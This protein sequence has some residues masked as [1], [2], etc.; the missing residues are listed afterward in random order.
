MNAAND[1]TNPFDRPD[2]L[3]GSKYSSPEMIA[4]IASIF[5]N[6]TKLGFHKRNEPSHVAFSTIYGRDLKYNVQSMRLKLAGHN[7]EDLFEPSVQA[8]ID[9]FEQQ[10][11]VALTPVNS[12]FLV[13]GFAANNWLFA[14]LQEYFQPL[15]INLCRPDCR[16]KKAVADGAVSFYI[17]HFVS[18]QIARATYGT[19][20]HTRYDPRDLE[21]QARKHTRF[22]DPVGDL[23]IPNKFSSILM[24]GTQV[25]QLHEFRK[26]FHFYTKSRPACG[27]CRV[28]IMCYEGDLQE[29]KWIDVERS[30][31]STRCTIYP[32]LS[33]LSQ[34][35]HPK[36]SGLDQSR[37]YEIDFEVIILFGQPELRAQVSWKH[38]GVEMRSPASI[39]YN[40]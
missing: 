1:N 33:E 3:S 34:T 7:V 29:P 12:V 6:T 32:D 30:S 36:K 37:Y 5:D 17:D 22:I 18:S 15:G 27:S 21:H 40:E 14:R 26:S 13:G 31:F 24:K 2:K 8:I 11:R 19:K 39:V 25:S 38:K 16:G 10:R 35:L 28:D 9:G 20:V 4:R 23:R